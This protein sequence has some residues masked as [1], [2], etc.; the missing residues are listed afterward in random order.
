MTSTICNFFAWLVPINITGSPHKKLLEARR[1]LE[2]LLNT[3]KDKGFA[4]EMSFNS[5]IIPLLDHILS[6]GEREKIFNNKG[7]FTYWE[8]YLSPLIKLKSMFRL[9]LTPDF[10]D[11]QPS[12]EDLQST[13]EEALKILNKEIESQRGKA[14]LTIGAMH[15]RTAE[16]ANDKIQALFQKK[17]IQ[18]QNSSHPLEKIRSLISRYQ[19]HSDYYL[20]TVQEKTLQDTLCHLDQT[21]T[22][23]RGIEAFVYSSISPKSLHLNLKPLA[24]CIITF[25]R[26][27][28]SPEKRDQIYVLLYK[29]MMP[30]GC[31]N[32]TLSSN[33]KVQ[34]VQTHL[35]LTNSHHL[36]C[37]WKAALKYE[38]QEEFLQFKEKI[39]TPLTNVLDLNEW[40]FLA[41]RFLQ[42]PSQR[43]KIQSL[44]QSEVPKWLE[45]VKHWLNND[46]RFSN[47][48]QELHLK[49]SSNPNLCKKVLED[50]QTLIESA[51]PMNQESENNQTDAKSLKRNIFELIETQL[52]DAF[53][54]SKKQKTSFED[55]INSEISTFI[56]K[57]TFY[58]TFYAIYNYICAPNSSQQHNLDLKK[59]SDQAF[60]R[61]MKEVEN[62]P[63]DKQWEIFLEKLKKEIKKRKDISSFKKLIGRLSS[64]LA[65][66]CIHFF[67]KS[68]VTSLIKF[69]NT[70]LLL[71]DRHPLSRMHL[72]P[73]NVL[74]RGAISYKQ[75]LQK[76]VNDTTGKKFG[77]IGRS[78]SLEMALKEPNG[79]KE[80]LSYNK[81]I[82]KTTKYVLNRFMTFTIL[83]TFVSLKKQEWH[84]W[85]NQISISIV[86][87]VFR[88][89]ISIVPRFFYSLAYVVATIIE[90]IAIRMI[91]SGAN[92]LIN[93]FH[94]LNRIVDSMQIS[95]KQPKSMN[96]I[97]KILLKLFL[98]IKKDL[99]E[100]DLVTK[101][102]YE[103]PE[104][105]KLVQE[106]VDN[107][108]QLLDENQLTKKRARQAFL[109]NNNA[110]PM[111]YLKK[112]IDHHLSKVI[113]EL[114]LLSL[115]S[116]LK[117]NN[118]QSSYYQL[119]QGINHSIY[120]EP[121]IRSYYSK[122]E[123][124]KLQQSLGN[125]SSLTDEILKQKFCED[126]G[127]HENTLTDKYIELKLKQKF[128]I[129]E[130]TCKA[131]IDEI[132][133]YALS[134][135]IDQVEAKHT[136]PKEMLA[137]Y[138][139]W[140]QQIAFS[141]SNKNYFV[142]I[143][144]A[145]E[146]HHIDSEKAIEKIY[147]E[148]LRITTHFK[149][150]QNLI[151]HKIHGQG[152]LA[153]VKHMLNDLIN[154]TIVPH[155]SQIKANIETYLIASNRNNLN[156]LK[157]SINHFQK[158]LLSQRIRFEQIKNI[159]NS[160]SSKS[161]DFSLKIFNEITQKMYETSYP[162]VITTLAKTTIQTLAKARLDA[163]V[164]KSILL[165]KDTNY[166]LSIIRNGIMAPLVQTKA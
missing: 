85:T 69:L 139:N 21:S 98:T 162:K 149:T 163:L 58:G 127:I 79:T 106:M 60:L 136:S 43:K 91:K 96:A 34:W 38:E 113:V 141:S 33:Q 152:H 89:L 144:K 67:S 133:D 82:E 68:L 39:Q 151:V 93:Y 8:T 48:L 11:P 47:C 87:Y 32:T 140:I 131:T 159:Q 35:C 160:F 41:L 164:D 75:A 29:E 97:D 3:L 123:K 115:Q 50:L 22:L 147:K 36:D 117:K 71:T 148:T 44:L 107:H 137:Q 109:G 57:T 15:K 128:S 18:N 55:E 17:L 161:Q 88:L 130:L 63:Q 99:K 7:R 120:P 166:I 4:F 83:S 158:N 53:K 24:Q 86:D 105:K 77:V 54:G 94:I 92:Y 104:S 101:L 70:R 150:Y 165:A 154:E 132:L 56:E 1:Q 111:T 102:D 27:K 26:Q 156:L 135:A 59:K 124:D 20:K 10:S 103:T 5:P 52:Q 143:A 25:I 74:N 51:P 2:I 45:T 126:F 138:I 49:L 14:N 73:I 65:M 80:K 95:Y 114:I 23:F 134:K 116:T 129:T 112:E 46:S 76:W 121:S 72:I 81:L 155:L 19:S 119:L 31:L 78:K 145:L 84:C 37:F 9:C 90:S 40:I 142:A 28:I 16:I 146:N 125:S 110:G 118:L 13:L 64:S 6:E 12:F 108:L 153:T 61:I 100:N 42:R 157:D 62:H 122:E 66:N 30:L